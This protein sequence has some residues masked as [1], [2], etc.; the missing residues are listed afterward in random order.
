MSSLPQPL[1]QPWQFFHYRGFGSGVLG[2][3]A[4]NWGGGRS[5]TH[6]PAWG[7]LEGLSNPLLNGFAR[8]FS[9]W[10]AAIARPWLGDQTIR[11]INGV[12]FSLTLKED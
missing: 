8:M 7:E 3:G 10:I 2:F 11:V 9:R 5:P 4:E 1:G 12:V 6:G